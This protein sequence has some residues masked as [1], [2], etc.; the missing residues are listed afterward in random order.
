MRSPVSALILTLNEEVNL[1]RCIES[2]QWVDDII[3]L[4]SG[5]KDVTVDI[6]KALGCRV[7]H[8]PFD[9]WSSHQNWAVKHLP[10]RHSWV[11]NI[12]ADEVVTPELREELSGIA[13]CPNPVGFA[14]LRMRRRDYFHGVW[15]KHS[16]F[17]PTWLVRFY[18][19]E[20]IRA[21]A[22]IAHAHGAVLHM[23][24]ARFGNALARMNVSADDATW[25]SGVDVLSFGAT[26][27]GAMGAEAIVFFDPKRAE[28]MSARRKRG[29]ALLSKHRFIAAQMEAFLDGD[30]WLKLARHANGMADALS[31]GLIRAG[32]APKW[33]VEANEVFAALPLALCDKLQAAGAVF[34]RWDTDTATQTVTVRLVTSFATTADEV[35]RFDGLLRHRTNLRSFPLAGHPM[36]R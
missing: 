36:P 13:T 8:R 16:T 23:D 2:L 21:L 28:G 7:F 15:L 25:K 22:D 26:K 29:G 18:R 4:D 1:P 5:S 19:P 9:N 12:D 30:L 35:E 6:A 27:G 11:L 17:Y 10:F 20:A 3:V 33:Q 14:A 32:F 34:Y 24:G 31:D